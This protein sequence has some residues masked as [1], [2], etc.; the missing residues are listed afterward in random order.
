MRLR[1]GDRV[2]GGSL[3]WQTPQPLASF[4]AKSPF[5]GLAVPDDV[6]VKRQVLA[7]PDGALAER[8]WAALADGTP[9][10]TA[11]PLGQGLAD[12]LPRHRRHELVEPAAF[13]HLR[14]HAAPDHRLLV[15]RPAAAATGR[16][17]RS[18][19]PPYRLLDGYGHFAT[20]GAEAPADRRRRRRRSSPGADASARPLRHRGRLPR[21]Q[22]PRRRRAT[23]PPFDA[24]G[25]RRRDACAPYPT[26]DADRDL[27][28]AARARASPCSLV[29]ALAVLWLNG[30][31]R[32]RRRAPRRRRS[33][34]SRPPS[35]ASLATPAAPSA[36]EAERPASPSTPSS[37]T[38][39]AY[40]ITGNAERRRR[41][42][43][44]ASS[45]CRRCSPSAPRSSRATR[46]AS[47][48]RKDELAFFPLLYWPI[49][50][51]DADAVAGDHGADR[52]LYAPGRLGAVRHARPAR[53]L[54]QRRTPSPARRRSSG[55]ARCWPSLD[56]PPLEP[57]P[58]DHV[59][60]KAF[61]LLN[62]FPGRY[63]G[64]PLWVRGDRDARSAPTARR[65]PATASR[66][67]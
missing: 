45:A 59:L 7:E 6:L 12:P 41:P 29:D 35:L 60:T 36:D 53:A 32:F 39:L 48:R 43:A 4:S 51:D 17:Q 20:P 15:R 58:A 21:A 47:T 30:G 54:D 46:S 42:A 27:A 8:T 25:H 55:S 26:A 62:D 13:R 2:L 61:Y 57:V 9:L 37:K 5:A 24:G 22:P 40:V 44:P 11:A 18:R 56:I 19:L 66:P 31:L 63:A 3:S 49:D 28:L 52:R 38:H 14:R 50:P 34:S 1:H 64:G 65:R 10:V 23:L 16:A 67:S 33:P